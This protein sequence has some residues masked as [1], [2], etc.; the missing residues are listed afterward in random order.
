MKFMGS[1]RLVSK[2]ILPIMLQKMEAHGIENWVEPFVGG[3]NMI[4]KVPS[5]YNRVGYDVCPHVI[6]SLITIRDFPEKLPKEVTEEEYRSV[7]GTSP[8]PVNSWVRFVCSFAGKF[9]GGYA[10]EEGSDAGTFAGRGYRN[11]KKQSPKLKGVK[12]FEKDYRDIVL[13]GRSLIY[14][15]P[16]YKGTTGYNSKSLDYDVFYDWC[17]KM[18][19]EGNLVFLSEYTAPEDFN[20]L[21]EKEHKVNFDVDRQTHSKS[22][23]KLFEI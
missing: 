22:V 12:L 11:A 10:R 18:S 15:D 5:S 14:C 19:E 9:D 23:E 13:E 4:D 1:K 6:E 7:L 16:P 3:G 20:L 17:R 8:H 21:W 2:H